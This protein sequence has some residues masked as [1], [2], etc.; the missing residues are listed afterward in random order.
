MRRA[1]HVQVCQM[2]PPDVSSCSWIMSSDSGSCSAMRFASFD[3]CMHYSSVM[4]RLTSTFPAGPP[5]E[6]MVYRHHAIIAAQR[7]Q[8][9]PTPGYAAHLLPPLLHAPGAP[10]QVLQPCVLLCVVPSAGG[11]R[12]N[13]AMT[14]TLADGWSPRRQNNDNV[15]ANVNA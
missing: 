6:T 14:I 13:M 10:G 8:H 9:S 5:L 4:P 2:N 12:A 7:C 11:L 15:G 1:L 3:T